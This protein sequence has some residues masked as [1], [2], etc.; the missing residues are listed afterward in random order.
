MV[1]YSIKIGIVKQ[2]GKFGFLGNILYRIIIIN[3]IIKIRGTGEGME[4]NL[5]RSEEGVK[6]KKVATKMKT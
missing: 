5:V 1:L 4:T 2:S 6:V 3:I